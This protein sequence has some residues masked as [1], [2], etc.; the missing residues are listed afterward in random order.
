MANTLFGDLTVVT[1]TPLPIEKQWF[2]IACGSNSVSLMFGDHK[3]L[4]INSIGV[5]SHSVLFWQGELDK[6]FSLLLE[7]L[8]S[9]SVIYKNDKVLI[10]YLKNSVAYG[11][12]RV[13]LKLHKNN[14]PQICNNASN[15]MLSKLDGL[16]D[17][18]SKRGNISACLNYWV[19]A[20]L[21]T[22]LEGSSYDTKLIREKIYTEFTSK[23]TQQ[24]DNIPDEIERLML[25]SLDIPRKDIIRQ[26]IVDM[27]FMGNRLSKLD[28]P[29]IKDK[30][31]GYCS[32]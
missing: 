16:Y 10:L 31:Y 17:L 28:K 23:V 1:N 32:E 30:S 18:Y 2:T 6:D 24:E 19:N 12:L 21:N 29:T 7:S 11:C 4:R 3:T 8:P 25:R 5:W 20:P 27:Y 15:V 9:G 13:S 26:I 22:D 14:E